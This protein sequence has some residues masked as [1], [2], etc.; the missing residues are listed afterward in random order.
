MT[1]VQTPPSSTV[2][3]ASAEVPRARIAV[4]VA[5]YQVDVVV[6]TKFTIE[7][8]IDDLLS[9]LAAAIND[10]NVD[11][12]PPN[13][14]WS[15]ARPGEPP[16]PRW[17]S[18]DDHDIVDGTVLM[19]S[20]VESAEVFTPVVEDVTDALALINEREFAEFDPDTA[21]V[22]GLSVLGIGSLG[23]A[24]MLSLVWTETGSVLWCG[25]PALLLGMICWGAAVAV[26]RTGGTRLT[27]GL[28]LSALPLL[29]AGSA[30]LV[31]PAYSEPG[32]FAPANLAAGAVVAAVAAVTMIRVARFGIA[33]LMAV[34]VLGITAT[35]ALLPLT[36]LDL[37]VRQVAGGAVFVALVLLTLAPRLAVVIARI[38]PPDLPDPGTE[39]A[40]ATLTDIFDAEAARDVDQDAEQSADAE[41]RRRQ[42]EIGIESQARLAVTSLRGLIVAISSLLAVAT[43][44]CAA[45]SPGGIREIVMGTAVAGILSMRSRWYPDRVQ[46]IALIAGAV[47]TVLGIAGVLV[48]AYGTPFARL[49]VVLIVAL[50]ACA[51]CVAALRL[52][53][54]RLTPVTRRVIDLVEYAL[55]LVVPVI[56][57]WIM[58]IYT[59]MRGL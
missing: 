55:I 33:T 48:G 2:G 45:V 50:I 42:H 13:G 4:M 30:M 51:G 54:K 39:V 23:I 35:C 36:Y 46:A 59:A 58:G 27:L 3:Q 38:R 9:V 26:R 6:P 8:F 57:F 40:P 18:L 37:A 14:Q 29:F 10:D 43:V 17:R 44:I 22:V 21:A 15:L 19:L 11:F 20:A 34:T 53:P 1:A 41:R 7:T 28:T 52:P 25:L 12:T 47:I 49:S 16:I 56:A 31:P 32:P 5:S 24:T